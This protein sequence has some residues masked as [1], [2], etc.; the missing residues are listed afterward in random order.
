LRSSIPALISNGISFKEE[1]EEERESER[2]LEVKG[3]GEED[4]KASKIVKASRSL[5]VRFVK[6][7]EFGTFTG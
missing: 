2:Q 3:G 7:S 1:E 6:N 5:P 4:E